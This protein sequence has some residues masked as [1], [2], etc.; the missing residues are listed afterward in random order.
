MVD[1]SLEIHGLFKIWLPSKAGIF[2]AA[3]QN[4]MWIPLDSK[5]WTITIGFLGDTEHRGIHIP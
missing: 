4:H 2:V 3:S 5:L 1:C